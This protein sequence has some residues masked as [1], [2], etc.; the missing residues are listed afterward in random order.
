MVI[1]GHDDSS[2]FQ[3]QVSI[4]LP[5][6]LI[7]GERIAT[8]P[9]NSTPGEAITITVPL[10]NIG[11]REARN[12]TVTFRVDGQLV[13]TCQVDVGALSTAEVSFSWTVLEG[14]HTLTFE[15]D[16]DGRIDE[17]L[18]TNNMA[19]IPIFAWESMDQDHEIPWLPILVAIAAIGIVV[20]IAA[21]RRR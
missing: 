13:D 21:T 6:L 9:L 4:M 14:N 3:I 16:P 7:D 12:A 18:E 8:E 2:L 20:A 15:L 1:D 10:E 19:S 17:I 11:S 5:D